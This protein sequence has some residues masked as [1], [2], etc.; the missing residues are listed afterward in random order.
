MKPLSLSKFVEDVRGIVRKYRTEAAYSLNITIIHER[1]AIGQRIVEE[2]QNGELRAEYGTN[3]INVLSQELTFELGK[4]Y[5]P[6]SLA[7]YRQLYVYFPEWE[8]LHTRVQ[9]LTWSHIK[10]ILGEKNEKARLWYMDEAA[11]QMWSVKTLERNVGS[12][13]YHRLLASSDKDA[14]S[15]EMN[16]LTAKD[17]V[18]IT[19]EQYIKS[20][21]VT[22]FLGIAKD[23]T[24]TES[25]LESALITHLQQFLMELGKGY[26]FVERQQHIVTDAGDYYIDLVFY[27]YLLKC[28]VLIDLKTT[29]ITHQDVGQMDMYV[30]MYDDLKRTQGDNPTIGILLCAETSEDI[31]KYSMLNGSKQLFAS[32]YLT[33]LPSEEELR[34]EIEIQKQLFLLQ[35]GGATK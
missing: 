2:D 19:P 35:K 14:V 18:T 31:A 30:R 22:E 20:P 3:L 13:Y 25:E 7:Y 15:D 5:N 9:N 8:I 12:Q 33:V 32:K 34:K 21:V 17:N 26:A 27:N 28:F 29:K 6:R 23:A 16:R 24:Y 1:W 10:A 11:Q 4:G